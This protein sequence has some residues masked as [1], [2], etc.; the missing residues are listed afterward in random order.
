MYL[1]DSIEKTYSV[2][3]LMSTKKE[4]Y[5][6]PIY[7]I[8][9]FHDPAIARIMRKH[10]PNYHITESMKL[11]ARQSAQRLKS[12]QGN[13]PR[14]LHTR[15]NIETLTTSPLMC[16]PHFVDMTEF[17][18]SWFSTKSDREKQIVTSTQRATFEAQ[19]KFC[20]ALFLL[21]QETVRASPISPKPLS[22]I[23]NWYL[24]RDAIINQTRTLTVNEGNQQYIVI[25]LTNGQELKI[26]RRFLDINHVFK[27]NDFERAIESTP[28]LYKQP[29]PVERVDPPKKKINTHVT[30]IISD[31]SL[32]QALR[33]NNEPVL[34]SE[35]FNYQRFHERLQEQRKQERETEIIALATRYR[36][37]EEV[38]A[39]RH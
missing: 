5:R 4:V 24:Q 11:I 3:S 17:L 35:T 8:P 2:K 23:Y 21:L 25:E 19:N 38:M 15:F 13:K 36:K 6:D 12:V 22:G 27:Q 14:F 1:H 33:K 31:V 26:D 10:D 18:K 9:H 20:D 32:P 37:K 30:R 39:V 28:N 29:K 7:G 34:L 16:F